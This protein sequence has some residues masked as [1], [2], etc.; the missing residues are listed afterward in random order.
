VLPLVDTVIM[1]RDEDVAAHEDAFVYR[2]VLDTRNMNIIG[3]T[4]VI[5]NLEGGFKSLLAM[6][7]YSFKVETAPGANTPSQRHAF[8]SADLAAGS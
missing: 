3:E 1:V 8:A 5:F 7:N 2:D 6:A 4:N